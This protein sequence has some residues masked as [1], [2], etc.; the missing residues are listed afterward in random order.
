M[1]L[2]IRI[3]VTLGKGGSDWKRRTRGPP[4]VL[5]MFCFLIWV[6]VSQGCLVCES[7]PAVYVLYVHFNK[8][9]LKC[10]RSVV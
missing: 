7:H 4:G 9:S 10:I 1:K 8:K 2:E 3:L 5:K 6:L